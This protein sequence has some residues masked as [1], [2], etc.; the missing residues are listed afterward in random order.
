MGGRCN[1]SL[2]QSMQ[3]S[4]ATLRVATIRHPLIE[5]VVILALHILT[6]TNEREG[7]ERAKA[8]NFHTA[9]KQILS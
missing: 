1:M 2:K 6:V 9:G 7:D 3:V 5:S 8:L 4:M